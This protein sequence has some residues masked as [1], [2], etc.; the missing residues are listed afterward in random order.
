MVETLASYTETSSADAA[1]LQVR[2]TYKT[3]QDKAIG[4]VFS[5]DLFPSLL[6]LLLLLLWLWLRLPL[7]LLLLWLLSLLLLH[8]QLPSSSTCSLSAQNSKR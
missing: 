8:L 4:L 1:M 7:V 3:R 6:L 5:P 2:R